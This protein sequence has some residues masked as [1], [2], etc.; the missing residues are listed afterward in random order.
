VIAKGL[1][2]AGLETT[3]V[4]LSDGERLTRENFVGGLAKL[5]IE[6]FTDQMVF[7]FMEAL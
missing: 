2:N 6:S 7:I 5:G 1:V 4:F 3:A